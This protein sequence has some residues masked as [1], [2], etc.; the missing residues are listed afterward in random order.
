MGA[1]ATR[2][3][4][5]ST[6]PSDPLPSCSKSTITLP[7]A[8]IACGSHSLPPARL[9][10]ETI[11]LADVQRKPAPVP[12]AV[13]LQHGPDRQKVAGAEQGVRIGQM[14]G[15]KR[16]GWAVLAA[17]TIIFVA[18]VVCIMVAEQS[19]NPKIAALGVDQTASVLQAG[20]N[21]INAG[22]PVT[23]V[24]ADFKTWVE[25]VRAAMP[26]L[27]GAMAARF[28]SADGL[29]PADAAVG[30]RHRD[31][32]GGPQ[33]GRAQPRPFCDDGRPELAGSRAIGAVKRLAQRAVAGELHHRRQAR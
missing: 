7:S 19:G 23:Q 18:A 15:D 11:P 33:G 5:G 32:R 25:Q 6:A 28:Q 29:A 10:I 1:T 4:K 3:R 22:K 27:P 8:L 31:H 12:A 21:D 30:G 13:A 2:P 26:E 17:M 24:V 9:P 14:V 20:G 16:Q